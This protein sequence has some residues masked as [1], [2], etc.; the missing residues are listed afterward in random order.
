MLIWFICFYEESKYIPS[1]GGTAPETGSFGN[2]NLEAMATPAKEQDPKADELDLNATQT[3]QSFIDP[4]IPMLPYR[5]RL[6]LITK[7]D[8]SLTRS[9]WTP[10]YIL[11]KF[12]HVMYTA[13]MYAF[14]LAWI[15]V[16]GVT[17]SVVFPYPPYNFGPL[18]VGNMSLGSFIGCIIGSLYAGIGSDRAIVF[19]SKRNHGYYEPEM[20]LHLNHLPAVAQAAGILMFGITVAKV[21]PVI[22]KTKWV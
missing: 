13:L 15:S 20:R 14:G 21:S 22:V 8:D 16:I 11:F 18:G 3:R 7:T 6:R 9:A 2:D 19:F 4:N 12:P 10:F 17:I 5:Q 1:V